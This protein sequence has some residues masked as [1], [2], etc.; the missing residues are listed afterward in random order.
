MGEVGKV[1]H[2]LEDPVQEGSSW[3]NV[4][5]RCQKIRRYSAPLILKN[6]FQDLPLDAD[7][8]PQEQGLFPQLPR[9]SE[10]VSQ[11][12]VDERTTSSALQCV[13]TKRRVLVIGDSLLRGVEAKVCRLD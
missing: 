12:P 10:H 3:K 1:Y 5:Q 6:H 13:R 2:Q 4:T 11:A 8:G 9:S 7:S